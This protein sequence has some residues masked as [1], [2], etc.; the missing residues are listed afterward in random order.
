MY[1]SSRTRSFKVIY[2]V[3]NNL[4]SRNSKEHNK[5]CAF[6]RANANKLMGNTGWTVEPVFLPFNAENSINY[7]VLY[8]SDHEEHFDF[9]NTIFNIRHERVFAESDIVA[10]LPES[11]LNFLSDESPELSFAKFVAHDLGTVASQWTSTSSAHK[12]NDVLNRLACMSIALGATYKGKING[13]ADINELGAWCAQ[14]IAPLMKYRD[15]KDM[16]D[17]A[18]QNVI[19]IDI[20]AQTSYTHGV[21]ESFCLDRTPEHA[22]TIVDVCR[23]SLGMD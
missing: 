7:S 8:T 3:D 23:K 14:K 12:E 9:C 13:N 22:E 21:N 4:V 10:V 2:N 5:A 15:F 17:N 1:N 19:L 18:P 11:S 16:A 6:Y 20:I